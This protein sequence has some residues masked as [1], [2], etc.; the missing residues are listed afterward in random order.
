[1]GSM[2]FNRG[3]FFWVVVVVIFLFTLGGSENFI[4][5]IIST[6]VIVGILY[7]LYIF[8]AKFFN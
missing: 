8:L 2:R 4:T 6:A 1:M 7:L 3:T 5:A